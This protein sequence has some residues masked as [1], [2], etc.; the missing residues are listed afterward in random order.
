MCRELTAELKEY[1][2]ENIYQLNFTTLILKLK[3][4]ASPSRELVIESG[5]RIHLTKHI[6]EKPFKPPQFC[7]F[8]RKYLANSRIQSVEQPDFERI[9][10]IRV[11]SRNNY[12][13]ICELF[14]KGNFILTDA[15]DTIISALTHRR[16]RDR[17]IL[18]G[19]KL[20]PPPP[21][22]LDPHKIGVE[23]FSKKLKESKGP[24]KKTLTNILGVNA[25][26]S[27]EFLRLTKINVNIDCSTIND[28]LIEKLWE[29]VLSILQK[30][31]NPQPCIIYDSQNMPVDVAPFPL[32]V[33]EGYRFEYYPSLNE[34]A[35]EYFNKKKFEEKG[36][37][38]KQADL[39]V[40]EQKRILEEQT[41]KLK[42]LEESSYKKKMLGDLIYKY[43]AELQILLHLLQDFK[44]KGIEWSQITRELEL[45]Q[46]TNEVPY[47]FYR[48]LDPKENKLNLNIEGSEFVLYINKTLYQNASAYY[49]ESKNEREKIGRV[50]ELVNQTLDRI[51]KFEKGLL[52][53]KAE[54]EKPMKTLEKRWF[55]KYRSFRSSEGFLVVS[56]K[57]ASS[58][59]ALVKRYM[60][61]NDLALHADI[62]GAPFTIIKTE[63]NI[64]NSQTFYEAAQFTAC[65]SR[66]WRDGFASTDVYYVKPEQISKTAPSGQ[67]L[68]RGSFI[69]RGQR[70]YIRKIPLRLAIGVKLDDE[71][72]SIIIGPP[73]SIV[74]QTNYYVEITTGAEESKNIAAKIR[75]QISELAP[76][77][78][79]E[80]ITRVSLEK[81]LTLIPYGKASIIEP[82]ARV[83]SS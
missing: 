19:E 5:R 20:K 73:S 25:I 75:F 1:Y 33:Y 72:P 22:G 14:G 42:E 83:P 21:K 77:E 34:A 71:E 24:L 31:K 15:Q 59:D 58:N 13:L 18:R 57:D 78:Y 65:Y 6:I 79:K 17:S 54:V 43:I 46:R 76:K 9:A 66:A 16:M 7:L 53:V 27:E 69:I 29:T 2:I 49:S 47:I 62:I 64:P 36:Q 8:L 82:R 44:Q 51:R 67:F 68:K 30:E 23:E 41:A 81:F 60:E 4:S 61:P 39:R 80:K 32:T 28:E 26:Y 40:E 52:T 45:K 56:G 37:P 48:S 70:N 3:R 50:K 10:I 11:A 38:R 55:D 63:G 35:D 12:N 74:P